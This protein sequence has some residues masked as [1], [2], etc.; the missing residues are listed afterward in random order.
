MKLKR[1]ISTQSAPAPEQI[2]VGELLYNANTGILYGKR[3][4]GN[5]I[6]WLGID[7]CDTVTDI[8]G[9]PVPVVSF[10][11]TS[12]FCCGGAALTVEV[13]NL[14]V[15]TRYKIAVSELSSN[16][17]VDISEFNT[18]LLPLNTSQR[19]IILNITIPQN[20]PTAILKFSIFQVS[21]INNI[22]IDLI[23]SEKL[24]VLS[25]TDC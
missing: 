2:E 25:C 10:S 21:T 15:D 9:Y 11:D 23:K 20:N 24:L 14:L 12:V 22:D 8:G 4:D 6:K 1:D 16:T 17:N 3:N 19:S 13:N 5:V 7:V 18:E